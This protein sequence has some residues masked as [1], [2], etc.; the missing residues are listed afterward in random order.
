MSF[1][2]GEEQA[3]LS[4]G[5]QF[6][7]RMTVPNFISLLCRLRWMNRPSC[8]EARAPPRA[9]SS[10]SGVTV[11][12]AGTV[13][14]PEPA[15]WE[16]LSRT[17]RPLLSGSLPPTPPL[18]LRQH[19]SDRLPQPACRHPEAP[20]SSSPLSPNRTPSANPP[21]R[22][23]TDP[24]VEPEEN[25]KVRLGEREKQEEPHRR[26]LSSLPRVCG[27]AAGQDSKGRPGR[28]NGDRMMWIWY[29][30]L[31]SGSGSRTVGE[32][33]KAHGN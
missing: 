23:Q 28:G 3:A 32:F 4:P 17:G 15:L 16:P 30:L 18:S 20:S 9:G 31:G 11:Q 10:V 14:G 2:Y 19:T 26:S 21:L 33:L 1:P 24:Q 29:L 12:V 27:P 8:N 25:Q 7:S 6:L 5:L 22:R 13:S